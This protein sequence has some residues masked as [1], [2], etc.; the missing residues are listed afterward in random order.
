MIIKNYLKT[1]LKKIIF[2]ILE[3]NVKFYKNDVYFL[4]KEKKKLSC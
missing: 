1:H 3:S 4:L 2:Y